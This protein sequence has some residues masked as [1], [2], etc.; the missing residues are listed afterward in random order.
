MWSSKLSNQVRFI[1]N[2]RYTSSLHMSGP[3]IARLCPVSTMNSPKYS[4]RKASTKE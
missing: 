2:D 1:F 4:T 3:S